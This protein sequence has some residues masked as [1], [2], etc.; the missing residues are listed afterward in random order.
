MGRWG[1]APSE[2]GS[3]DWCAFMS[4]HT[5]LQCLSRCFWAKGP[6]CTCAP[7]HPRTKP[8]PCYAHA[9]SIVPFGKRICTAR[10][11]CTQS[12]L[13]SGRPSGVGRGSRRSVMWTYSY[14]PQASCE[15]FHLTI[16]ELT[17]SMAYPT[18]TIYHREVQV[19]RRER[20]NTSG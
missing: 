5:H 17:Y 6:S 1:C 9:L 19:R 12:Y 3:C 4:K 14:E 15:T 10:M 2:R 16:Q 20:K 11:A 13:T 8:R 7:P 18:F